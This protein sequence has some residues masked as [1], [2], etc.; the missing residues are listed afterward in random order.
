MHILEPWGKKVPI[1]VRQYLDSN[2][3]KGTLY[4]WVPQETKYPYFPTKR[5]TVLPY[6]EKCKLVFIVGNYAH[7]KDIYELTGVQDIE[8]VPYQS[9]FFDK[10]YTTLA[11][12]SNPQFAK[13]ENYNFQKLF[14]S[15]NNVL[16]PDRTYFVDTLFKYNLD[17]YLSF[18]QINDEHRMLFKYWKNA[19]VINFQGV[20][21]R[22]EPWQVSLPKEWYQ[23]PIHLI[24]ETMNE[25]LSNGDIRITEKTCYPLLTGKPFLVA[26]P[27]GF[28]KNLERLGF[29]L[30]TEIFD[31]SFD[32][33]ENY[34]ERIDCMIKMVSDLKYN[35]YN[36]L[37]LRCYEKAR[38]NAEYFIVY[39]NRERPPLVNKLAMHLPDE[40]DLD[41]SIN[42]L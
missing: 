41:A 11:K 15:L 29:E 34:E 28:H 3:V 30:Y 40:L 38:R 27:Q 20:E 32:S 7:I 42:N 8:I 18:L 25:V 4:I 35:S 1:N 24:S 39:M 12:Q 31:Y 9:Y 26:G 14:I 6:K 22:K 23:A 33:I 10:S 17:G 36:D 2:K 37:Y 5:L 16:R 21:A 13:I 19:K